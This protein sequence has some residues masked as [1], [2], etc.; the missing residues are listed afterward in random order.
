[1]GQAASGHASA[2][3]FR[4]EERL[5][6]TKQAEGEEPLLLFEGGCCGPERVS[7]LLLTHW[8]SIE[9]KKRSVSS[10]EI[11][12]FHSDLDVE[13]E[14]VTDHYNINTFL[15][16]LSVKDILEKAETG[17]PFVVAIT[18]GSFGN[19]HSYNFLCPGREIGNSKEN[20]EFPTAYDL[21][22]ASNMKEKLHVVA[23]KA[24]DC[25]HEEMCSVSIGDEFL[26]PEY[27]KS[28]AVEYG[29]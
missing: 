28:Q 6:L 22:I 4:R 11:V 17:S 14:D 19:K 3:S 9:E 18:E 1:W 20:R 5:F 21:E 13:V 7:H 24:F 25:P 16:P 26:I 8:Q 27:Q 29:K 12:H 15:Q 10:K 2:A 23:T